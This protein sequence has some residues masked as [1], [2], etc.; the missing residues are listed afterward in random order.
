MKYTVASG[1]QYFSGYQKVNNTD[2]YLRTGPKVRCQFINQIKSPT[3]GMCQRGY[4]I[5]SWLI[6]IWMK[7]HVGSDNNCI[8]VSL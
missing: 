8:M 6:E 4:E 1:W 2:Y 7:I 3:S 5:L